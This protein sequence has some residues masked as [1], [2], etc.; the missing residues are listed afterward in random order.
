[1]DRCSSL[2]RQTDRPA[3]RG[4]WKAARRPSSRTA[5]CS[6]R[7]GPHR[8]YT[9]ALRRARIGAPSLGGGKVPPAA[10]WALPRYTLL[11]LRAA[12]QQVCYSV[13]AVSGGRRGLLD[14][15]SALLARA[16]ELRDLPK[17]TS[18]TH[19]QRQQLPAHEDARKRAH[20]ARV[21]GQG[22]GRV[23]KR[24]RGAG[25]WAVAG[26]VWY[27]IRSDRATAATC[28]SKVAISALS[29]LT[30]ASSFSRT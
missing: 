4:P 24:R 22:V 2:D 15:L 5:R 21:R 14:L 19:A 10:A 30:F 18:S 12:L 20:R 27:Q 11:E 13:A 1:M 29:S 9:R 3:S 23:G 8:T 25:A 28:R 17:R 26:A 16:L 7:R 6:P